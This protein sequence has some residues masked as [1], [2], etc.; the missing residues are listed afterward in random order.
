MSD[1]SIVNG[2]TGT[3]SSTTVRPQYQSSAHTTVQ[4]AARRPSTASTKNN[5]CS[6]IILQLDPE[7]IKNLI[8][9]SLLSG[10]L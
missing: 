8:C 1:V 6:D 10:T 2:L 9:S 7:L 5:V 4:Q 3:H